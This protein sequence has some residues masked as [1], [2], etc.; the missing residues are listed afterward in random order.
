MAINNL[1]ET[2]GAEDGIGYIFFDNELHEEQTATNIMKALICQ[3]IVKSK[4]ISENTVK[5]YEWYTS[6]W[7]NATFE[8]C[9]AILL[10]Q[11]ADFERVYFVIDAIEK[12]RV[13]VRLQFLDALLRLKKERPQLYF[14]ITSTDTDLE[15]VELWDPV[16]YSLEARVEDLAGFIERQMKYKARLQ[17]FFYNHTDLV[18]VTKTSLIERADGMYCTS[19]SRA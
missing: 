14:L 6:Q 7:T 5:V 13:Q 18:E 9:C 10:S 15:L 17:Q 3:L 8:D 12:C 16:L 1:Q 2:R 11:I 4:H 19:V